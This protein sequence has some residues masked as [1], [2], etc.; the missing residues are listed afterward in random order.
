MIGHVQGGWEYIWAAY[1]LSWAGMAVFGAS[2]VPEGRNQFAIRQ[3]I[4]G[5]LLLLAGVSLLSYGGDGRAPFTS[6]TLL[7]AVTLGGG[8]LV[9]VSAAMQLIRRRQTRSEGKR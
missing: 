4:V 5:A 6:P 3:A 8:V 7:L 2:V 1:F 9:V